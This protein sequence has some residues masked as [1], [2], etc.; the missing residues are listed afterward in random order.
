SPL[1]LRVASVQQ[2]YVSAARRVRHLLRP[3]F[4]RHGRADCGPTALCVPAIVHRCAECT[5]NTSESLR[6][7]APPG[8]KFS[9][10]PAADPGWRLIF[11]LG[12]AASDQPLRAAI[13]P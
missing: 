5:G 7:R 12:W 4:R 1:R 6:S 8:L 3:T 10:L 9:R 11:I 13:R 2:T